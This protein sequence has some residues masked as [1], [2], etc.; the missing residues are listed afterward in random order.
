ML[1]R[2]F[3]VTKD[4]SDVSAWWMAQNWPVLPKEYL[5]ENGFIA[6]LDNEK[7][8]AAWMLQLGKT[9]IYMFEWLVGNPNVNWEIRAKGI[10]TLI[11]DM[12]DLSKKDGAQVILG[13]CKNER[14][15]TKLNA[16]GFENDNSDMKFLMRKL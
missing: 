7:V 16:I 10:E 8:A 3:D 6:E 1:T 15:I 4:Y 11:N 14:L 2:R 9:P 12:C 5:A 13:I